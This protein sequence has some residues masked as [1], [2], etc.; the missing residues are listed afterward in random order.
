MRHKIYPLIISLF[1]VVGMVGLQGCFEE[2]YS[3]PGYGYGGYP[4]YGYGGYPAYPAYSYA[5]SYR[6]YNYYGSGYS[7]GY[8]AGERHEEHEEHEEH[9]GQRHPYEGHDRD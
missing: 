1:F 7:N 6:P 8:R 9:H 2:H 3:D 5:P 4:A